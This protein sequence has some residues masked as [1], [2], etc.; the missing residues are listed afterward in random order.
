V[1]FD[2]PINRCNLVSSLNSFIAT[3]PPEPLDG[4]YGRS[5]RR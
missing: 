3:R 2:T 1:K 4:P 5:K